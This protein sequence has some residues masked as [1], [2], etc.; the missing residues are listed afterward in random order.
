[1]CL[2][3]ELNSKNFLQSKKNE[4]QSSYL[5]MHP[6]LN[7]PE[8]EKIG[9]TRKISSISLYDQANLNYAQDSIIPSMSRFINSINNMSHTILIPSKLH[10][11][12]CEESGDLNDAKSVSS[13]EGSLSSSSSVSSNLIN[14]ANSN[15]ETSPL[16][17]GAS[18]HDSYKMLIQAKDDLLWGFKPQ[19][20]ETKSTTVDQNNNSEEKKDDE[21]REDLNDSNSQIIN[22]FR[23][24]IQ[25]LNTLFNNFSEMAEF[26]TSKYQT[27]YES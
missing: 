18:L 23:N 8:M 21:D 3:V 15:P 24:N 13:D 9:L 1:V 20:N 11:F 14:L 2:P 4:S 12:E 16:S 25:Q 17:N 22:Q 26:L 6:T 27:V 10:D 7:V 5:K 19:Q